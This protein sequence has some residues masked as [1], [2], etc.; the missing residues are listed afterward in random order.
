MIPGNKAWLDDRW[1]T[2]PRL[3]L[4]RIPTISARGGIPISTKRDNLE[5]LITC[6]DPRRGDLHH[7]ILFLHTPEEH[8]RPDPHHP[9]IFHI[10]EQGWR[11]HMNV[12]FFSPVLQA[13]GIRN[14][15]NRHS[16]PSI[17]SDLFL[18]GYNHFGHHVLEQ[19]GMMGCKLRSFNHKCNFT[20]PTSGFVPRPRSRFIRIQLV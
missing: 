14:L 19:W 13:P 5:R 11:H 7:Y 16:P 15:D 2:H 1:A 20:I 10:Q 4:W 17:I 3:D 12:R 18:R 6:P 9:G 8:I